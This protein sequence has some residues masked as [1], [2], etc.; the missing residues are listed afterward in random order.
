MAQHAEAEQGARRRLVRSCQRVLQ[1]APAFTH[2]ASREPVRPQRSYEP[3]L[4]FD[5][6]VVA[7]PFDRVAQVGVVCAQMFEQRRLVAGPR[8]ELNLLGERD[9]ELCVATADTRSLA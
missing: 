4:E 3:Q 7:R 5:V 8:G 6:A 2:V 1:P 9:E